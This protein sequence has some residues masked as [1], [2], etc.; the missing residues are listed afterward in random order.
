MAGI[1]GRLSDGIGIVNAGIP[2]R[3]GMSKSN[4]KNGMPGIE[5]SESDGSGIANAGICRLQL[6][7]NEHACRWDR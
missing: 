6:D 2:G 3:P 4:V 5:G 7:A 1:C